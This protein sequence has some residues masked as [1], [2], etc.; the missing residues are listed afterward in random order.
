MLRYI[1]LLFA[2]AGAGIAHAGQLDAVTTA[3]EAGQ[4]KQITSVVVARHGKLL[5]EHYFDKEGADALRNTRSVTKTVTGMLVG[6]AVERKLLRADSPVLPHFPELRP[7]AYADARKNKIT[8]EDLLT[9]SSLLECDDEDQ[10]SRGNEERMYLVEDW[11]R[12]VA[13]LPIKGFPDWTLRPEKSP[14]GRAFSYCTAGTALL[15]PLLEK[16]SRQSVPEFAAAHLFTPLGID[17]VKWQFQPKGTAMTGGGLQ[18]RSVDLMKL[19][20]LYLNGGR[21]E[22]RQVMPA[23][24]VKRSIAPHANAREGYDYGYLWWLQSFKVN[25]RTIATYGMAGAGGNKVVV[26]PELDAVVVITTNNFQQ[27]DAHP[28]SDKLL[29]TLILPVLMQP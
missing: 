19:G 25:E 28:L 17:Q 26:L 11:S 16:V 15:G 29:T 2:A 3:I 24:W 18:L 7:L 5:Y 23:A 4:F 12:F 6:L 14:Y 22:G 1:P 13:D 21:W 8:V 10:N 27:R 20:Q 9:M